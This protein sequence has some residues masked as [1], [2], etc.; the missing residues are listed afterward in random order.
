MTENKVMRVATESPIKAKEY[1]PT[2]DELKREY[3]YTVAMQLLD[4]LL[5]SSLISV[6]EFNKSEAKFR[7]RF[8]P[9]LA[10][11]MPENR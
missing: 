7:K 11:V 2:A 6:D 8:S 9:H 5:K 3:D 1:I 4:S 10:P